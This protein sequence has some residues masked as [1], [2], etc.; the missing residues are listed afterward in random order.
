MSSSFFLLST[1]RDDGVDWDLAGFAFDKSHI[2]ILHV[3]ED[4][5]DESY[6][7]DEG[8]KRSVQINSSSILTNFKLNFAARLPTACECGAIT[9]I[10]F[11]RE[12]VDTKR[13]LRP[14]D[15]KNEP[16]QFFVFFGQVLLGKASKFCVSV[17]LEGSR[18]KQQPTNPKT[19]E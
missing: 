7:S 19:Y 2:I 10:V 3:L 8:K 17:H 16:F 18:R 13:F 1:A 6:V 5:F 4:E 15:K 9:I 11:W 12:M 14:T